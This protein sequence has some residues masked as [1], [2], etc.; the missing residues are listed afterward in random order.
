MRSINLLVY[1]PLVVSWAAA[2]PIASLNEKRE[3]VP[4]VTDPLEGITSEV[5][6]REYLEDV[7]QRRSAAKHLRVKRHDEQEPNP[8]PIRGEFG[9]PIL[10]RINFN[11]MP[12]SRHK[13]HKGH[14]LTSD[15]TFS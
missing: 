9:A 12:F 3:A 7:F 6:P 1:L 11:P 5:Y 14:I 8:Q 15:V 2:G 10:G 4:A 13:Y